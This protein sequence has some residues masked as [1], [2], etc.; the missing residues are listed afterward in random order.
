MLG[1]I[2]THMINR[3]IRQAGTTVPDDA[4]KWY[5]FVY[6]ISCR[7]ELT[8][9]GVKH[10]IKP[11]RYT[12]I[13]PET[14]HSEVHDVTGFVFFTI[15]SCDTELPDIIADDSDGKLGAI[16][17]KV[18]SEHSSTDRYSLDLSLI[19]L[20]ELILNVLRLNDYGVESVHTEKAAVYIETHYMEKIDFQTLA[21][22]G[23]Y[24]YDY[25]RH[26]FRKKYGIP[27][28]RYQIECRLTHAA[29]M[30]KLTNYNCTEIASLCGFSNSVQFS[31]MFGEKYGMSPTSWR[32]LDDKSGSGM[33]LPPLGRS[34]A[35]VFSEDGEEVF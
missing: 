28:K 17:E 25:F 12:L 13:R 10:E 5:E 23:N 15:F 20:A 26:M 19:A 31:A 11:G 8:L 27:P 3:G 7:G 33:T 1:G 18:F 24:S 22:M 32:A 16:C 34:H 2:N 4:H 6:Y 29:K 30:L 14:R 21:R 9:K 35:E